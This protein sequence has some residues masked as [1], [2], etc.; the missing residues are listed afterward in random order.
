MNME[1]RIET[2]LYEENETIF[3]QGEKGDRCYLIEAGKVDIFRIQNAKSLKI[4]QLGKGEIFGE[5][6]LIDNSPRMATAKAATDV[7]VFAIDATI[8]TKKIEASDPFIAGLVKNLTAKARENIE[9]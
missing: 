4:N 2:T 7:I 9:K 8:L 1:N 5:M 3:R 6:A